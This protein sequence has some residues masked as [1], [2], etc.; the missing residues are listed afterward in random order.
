MSRPA[1]R[2]CLLLALLLALPGWLDPAP[3]RAA[4]PGAPALAPPTRGPDADFFGIVGRDPWYEWD[5]D[6]ARFPGA[7]NR[8]ALEGM[9]RELALASAG[10][11]RIELRA[12][13]AGSAAAAAGTID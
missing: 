9:A 10:W 6:P 4:Q 1:A 3:A 13:Y 2:C 8:D 5:T 7:V 11:V 12:E